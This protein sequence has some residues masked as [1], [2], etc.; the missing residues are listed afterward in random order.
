MTSILQKAL[1]AI[2][3]IRNLGDEDA[4]LTETTG[5][6]FGVRY[7]DATHADA[8]VDEGWTDRAAARARRRELRAS[9]AVNVYLVKITT[10]RRRK[11]R[12][13]ALEKV[14]ASPPISEPAAGT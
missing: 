9:G 8:L 5:V 14:E 4:W 10:R 1:K 12:Q 6:R 7:T 13:T 2:A 11:P 3:T